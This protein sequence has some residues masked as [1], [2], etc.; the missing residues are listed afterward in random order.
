MTIK[1]KLI[2]GATLLVIVTGIL[3]SS[4]LSWLSID[5][6][7]KILREQSINKLVAVREINKARI[8]QYFQQIDKQML[9]F[10][11][12]RM[13]I[14]AMHRFTQ[15][16]ENFAK[17]YSSD[18]LNKMRDYLLQYYR[19]DF[20]DAYMSKNNSG[21]IDVQA[22]IAKLDE[23]AVVMQYYYI[24][25][26]VNPLGQ[27][28]KLNSA[29]DGSLYSYIHQ[30]YHPHIQNFQ[31]SFGYYD[32][33]LVEPESGRVVYSVFKELD[34]ATSLLHGA[35]AQSGLGRAFQRANQLNTA[36]TVLEDF[37]PYKPSYEAPAAFSATPIF[38]Q[39]KK[40]G[41][42]IFQM[43]I[44]E[45]NN[46]M[47]NGQRWNASGLGLTGESY[48]V[49]ADYRARSLSRFLIED[50]NAYIETLRNAGVEAELLD[51]MQSKNTNIGLQ[52]IE[53]LGVQAAI[54]GD[55]GVDFFAN[56]RGVPVISAYAPLNIKD[57][58]WAILTEIDQQEAYAPVSDMKSEIMH[59]TVITVVLLTLL[60][61]LAG[62]LF[63]AMIIG[64][65]QS[66][67]SAIKSI[68]KE[69][70][71][72]LNE[73][74][75]DNGNDEFAELA[76][77]LNRLLSSS[78]D[79]IMQIIAAANQLGSAAEGLA[80]V[81]ANT[82]QQVSQQCQQ[83]EQVAAAMNEMSMTVHEVANSA[84][85]TAA[86]AAE[87]DR[88]AKDGREIICD[89][90]ASIS[91]LQGNIEGAE[92]AVNRLEKDSEEIGSVLDVIRGIAEQTNL[93][94]LNAA[95]EAARAGEQG[96]GFAVVADEVRTLASRTQDST[97]QIQDMIERL[98]NGASSSVQ[99]MQQ[100]CKMAR[101]TADQAQCGQEALGE[102]TSVIAEINDMTTKIASASQQ[103]SAVAEEI[104]ANVVNI[105]NAASV[106]LSASEE[107]TQ[108]S[109]EMRKLAEH[110]Q[111]T[112][113]VFI[114]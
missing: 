105:S 79:A 11:N 40:I 86:K 107:V 113:Q 60:S 55:T 101:E 67:V 95:I 10:A 22:L 97:Q 8:E 77:L 68:V 108:S 33:F 19:K 74:I 87:G 31:S 85:Q 34:Y 106:T 58:N 47:T 57:L 35:Y 25:A 18:E 50:K 4:V 38:D 39:G 15:E 1:N 7:G 70:K 23:V 83:T 12:D 36:T 73:R 90:I 89:T 112:V 104:N 29:E 110:L 6:A 109:N 21:S 30:Y 111:S 43:P 78:R 49:G 64:P 16:A 98:Q 99:V 92:Q 28:D 56:Y 91:S 71:I 17:T 2:L 59:I 48:L 100:S 80:S 45:I 62:R 75:D 84:G 72:N 51:N 37:A 76:K 24:S 96:R 41:I 3:V 88:Q 69:G 66:F 114:I 82:R 65:M 20:T 27:K 46:I 93:L 5:S 26:N 14:D 42:L 63:A 102:I 44:N 9:T 103:Q 81:S 52:K 53:T 94:A 32:I 54:S 61:W 13:I